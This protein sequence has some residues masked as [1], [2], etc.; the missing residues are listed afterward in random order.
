[1]LGDFFEPGYFDL[2][3]L[4]AYSSC[5]VRWLRDRLVDRLHPLPHYRIEGKIL[6]KREEFDRWL[7]G[8]HIVNSADEL[9]EI[10][11]SV[12]AHMRP[13]KRNA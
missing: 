13:S 5:S 7:S 10:V 11:D 12:V 3:A 6:V 9:S 8:S 2:K 1:M 4:A